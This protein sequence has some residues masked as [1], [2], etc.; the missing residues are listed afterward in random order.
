MDARSLADLF[1]RN[2]RRCRRRAGLTQEGLAR[3]I[4]MW[5]PEVG[6]LER[7]TRLPQLETIIRLS[8]GLEVSP[9]DLMRGMRWRP[10]YYV[11]GGFELEDR[12]VPFQS[13]RVR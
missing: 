4:E 3:P 8:A 12:S 11:E 13:E 10:G 9:C 1:G 7:G 2:L 6:E 5:G